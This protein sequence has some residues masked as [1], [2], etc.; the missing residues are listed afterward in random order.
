VA[1]LLPPN[2]TPLE[3]ALAASTARLADVPIALDPL[4]DP[5]TCP[6][7]LLPW[8]AWGESVD[9]W[10]TSWTEARKREAIAESILLHR[11]KGT[12]WAVET[13]LAR[14][15]ALAQVVEW[16]QAQPPLARHTFEIRIPLDATSG[17]RALASVAEHIIRDVVRVKPLREHLVVVQS[18]RAALTIAVH[19]VARALT[20]R[21]DEI[22]FAD[23]RSQPWD[24]LLQTEDGEPLEADNG[25][26]L[27]TTP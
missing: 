26:F 2:A 25:T 18:L 21:R 15:D 17:D 9:I 20:S 19:A 11:R 27:D 8:L 16:H 4:I 24:A 14:I 1:D 13:I 22:T 3:R 23:D 7:E 5:A 6:A 12:R 10:E